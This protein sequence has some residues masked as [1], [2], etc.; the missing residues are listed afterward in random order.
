M[1]FAASKIPSNESSTGK[2]KQAESCPSGVPALNRVGVLGTNSSFEI[3][4]LNISSLCSGLPPNFASDRAIDFATLLK[5]PRGVST[6]FSFSSLSRYLCL[7][8]SMALTVSFGSPT[9]SFSRS[10]LAQSSSVGKPGIPEHP[11]RSLLSSRHRRQNPENPQLMVPFSELF[12]EKAHHSYCYPSSLLAIFELNGYEGLGYCVL[13]PIRI[14]ID[15][16]PSRLMIFSITISDQL[17]LLGFEYKFFNPD[18]SIRINETLI[19]CERCGIQVCHDC[20][21]Q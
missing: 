15:T 1:S 3:I 17:Q 19:T 7:K 6:I 2:T 20:Q 9:S 8:T 11:S 4:S 16:L 5:S 14:E 21:L 18:D 10:L 12:A 13:D